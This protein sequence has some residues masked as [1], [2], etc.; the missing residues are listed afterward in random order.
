MRMIWIVLALVG[1]MLFFSHCGKKPER[2]V[3]NGTED[4]KN[5]GATL[6]GED[7]L[8]LSLQCISGVYTGKADLRWNRIN[9][10]QRITVSI[11]FLDNSALIQVKGA[12]NDMLCT[13]YADFEVIPSGKGAGGDI[14]ILRSDNDKLTR[15]RRQGN[16]IFSDKLA[17]TFTD[18]TMFTQPDDSSKCTAFIG[19]L[20]PGGGSGENNTIKI[21]RRNFSK[22]TKP[23]DFNTILRE[24]GGIEAFSPPTNLP[25]Q[26]KIEIQ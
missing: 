20:R 5:K 22:A 15:K 2:Q 9:S 4:D 24:C 26:E 6:V 14:S 25:P 1:S 23:A 7:T 11:A 19:S 12:D 17:E 18:I 21:S 10:A 16:A 13:H 3:I 8:D